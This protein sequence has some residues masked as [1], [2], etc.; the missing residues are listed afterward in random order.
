MTAAD[1]LDSQ[2]SVAVT[3]ATPLLDVVDAMTRTGA[4]AALVIEDERAI[5]IVTEQDIIGRISAGADWPG[6]PVEQ[7][8]TAPV[9][10]T[11]DDTRCR[12]G[13]ALMG[14][15][16]IRHL[17]I[18]PG[19][20]GRFRVIGEEAFAAFDRRRRERASD[21]VGAIMQYD[22]PA[23][24]P[25]ASVRAAIDL[26]NA[27]ASEFVVAAHHQR[28]LGTLT[29][30]DLLRRCHTLA[31]DL[32][33]RIDQLTTSPP[34]TIGA[35]ATLDQALDVMETHQV[36]VLIVVGLDS[37]MQGVVSMHH[38]V[39]HQQQRFID[40]LRANLEACAEQ[41][42]PG[43]LL[44]VI[45]DGVLIIER[46]SA[47]IVEANPRIAGWL[48]YAAA[49][50]TGMPLAALVP[51]QAQ[52]IH[53]GLDPNLVPIGPV[54]R[55]RL[56][57]SDGGT[58][59]AEVSIKR[60]TFD[61]QALVVAVVRDQTERDRAER[62]LRDSEERLRQIFETN[63]AIKLILDPEDGRIVDANQAAS[64]FYGYPHDRLVGMNIRQINRM[65]GD[66]VTQVMRQAS[67]QQRLAFEF[68]HQLADGDVRD[69]EVFTGPLAYRGKTLLYSIIHDVSERTAATRALRD[70]E[71]R[72]ELALRGADL[73]LWD[74]DIASGSVTYSARWAQMLGE[75]IDDVVPHVD[76][77]WSRVHPDDVAA[78]TA[79]LQDHLDGETQQFEK[80]Y[81]MAHGD[82]GWRWITNRGRVVERD[83][84]G[85][86]LRAAGTHMDVTASRCAQDRL[87]LVAQVFDNGNEGVIITDAE[88]RIVEVN[89]AFSAIT[90]Y[91][92]DEVIGKRPQ[93]LS[94]GRHDRAFY[95]AL[96]QSLQHS[97]RWSGEIWNR[98]KN[99]EVYPEWLS[100]SA[101]HDDD[102]KVCNYVAVFSDISEQHRS[103]AELEHLAHHDALTNLP[104]RLLF[105][106]RLEY[107]IVHAKRG[108]NALAVLFID[109]D[110]FKTIND[111]LGHATGDEVL[112]V[113]AE[114]MRAVLRAD[115]TMARVGGDEFI[116][117]LENVTPG[118]AREVA[119]KLAA[120]L[121][122]PLNLDDDPLYL[123]LSVGISMYP[124]DGSDVDT[125]LRNA[126]AAMYKAK[127]SGRDTFHFY[128]PQLT[129][130]AREQVFLQNHLRRAID[131]A[132]F[133]VFYQPQVDIETGRAT[134]VEALLRWQHPSEGLIMPGRFIPLLEEHG[135]MRQVGPW[136]LQQACTDYVRWQQAGLAPRSLAV[137]LSGT[138]IHGTASV[139]AIAAI[140]DATGMPPEH[141]ELEVTETF[142]MNDPEANINSL[143][144]LRALGIRLAIDDFGTGYSSLTYLKR[145]PINKLKID[146]SFVMD[147]PGDA[148][149]E[150]IA[151]AVIGLGRT[152]NLDIV[153]EGVERRACA[154]FLMREG[155][156]NGQ[157]YLWG[158]P[159][160][161]SEI[162]AWLAVHT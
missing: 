127:D 21:R 124:R 106:A 129:D 42:F 154:E 161:E 91:A 158:K 74:W 89:K 11:G 54:F 3:R 109:V 45:G 25:D 103:R 117:L 144:R 23:L 136:V 70:S 140:L 94:S 156:Y 59:P 57:R 76:S 108:R 126:D 63:Q 97:G 133:R 88:N 20:D 5:G 98:R 22:P 75:R 152:L 40:T 132:E 39:S 71:E 101:V 49:Q 43:Q 142:V 148:D 73:G 155:C 69:V 64:R 60:V 81:R 41:R 30:Q 72:L 120:A 83:A 86:P 19:D 12:T 87:R 84:D 80:T 77:W 28:A 65:D 115:D 36:R 55:A 139:D 62:A 26:M 131:H 123:S 37:R 137:N 7:L 99:C 52:Q 68:R 34:L 66:A 92:A 105:N 44:D 27:T 8:M 116:I 16:G 149:D 128:T 35:D 146:R 48:G 14:E 15:Q 160:A 33:L 47:Q 6:L 67:Q 150:A 29:Q 93:L 17:V 85:R 135:L 9:D 58:M 122:T 31:A 125:L 114:R 112:R 102:G 119:E 90:G 79:A 82:G 134:G 111:S 118:G 95:Q 159:V 13:Y 151:R 100:I 143:H 130:E 113:A 53:W 78:V 107:A 121:R 1:Q 61:E 110:R 32:D 145:L 104:N 24:P 46:D 147:I 141:L 138:Q 153:A 2:P 38:L 96:W 50:M 10:H 157:G 162:R 18:E 56:Q 51:D 4:T